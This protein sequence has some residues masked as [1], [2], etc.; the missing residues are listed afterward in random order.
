MGRS[1]DELYYHVEN[2]YWESWEYTQPRVGGAESQI[3]EVASMIIKEC[4]CDPEEVD[5]LKDY[6][7]RIH[8]GLILLGG[9][10]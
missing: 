4:E 6:A 10:K 1:S 5:L 8:S 9:F 7:R 3:A 2:R